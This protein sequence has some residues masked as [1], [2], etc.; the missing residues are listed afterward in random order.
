MRTSAPPRRTCLF[1]PIT[2]DYDARVLSPR[3]WTLAQSVWAAELARDR[4]HGDGLLELCAGAGHIGLAA[5]VLADRDLVQVELDPVAAAYAAANARRAGWG[6]RVEIRTAALQTALRAGESF[7][8]VLADPPYLTTS[9]T[10]R[11]PEDP[12]PAIDGGPDGLRVIRA[13]LQVAAEHLAHGG[14]LLL[15]VAGAGQA[16]RV[17][18]VLQSNPRWGLRAGELRTIDADRAVLGIGRP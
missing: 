6:R 2:V 8:I 3:P 12:L 9:A 15:Q 13:C 7:P 16:T 18:R 17:E 14:C 11:W 10:A 4:D 1:G 5:A